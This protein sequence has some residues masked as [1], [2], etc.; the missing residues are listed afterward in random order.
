LSETTP[1]EDENFPISLCA[2]DAIAHLVGQEPWDGE[3]S[4][5]ADFVRKART[6]AERAEEESSAADSVRKAHNWADRGES[7]QG[8]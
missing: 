6:W 3:E 7:D 4:S 5:A 1:P 2:A 8:E